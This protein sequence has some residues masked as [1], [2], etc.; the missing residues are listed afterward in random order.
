MKLFGITRKPSR[1]IIPRITLKVLFNL[2]AFQM[3]KKTRKT[4]ALL[5]SNL[6]PLQEESLE[7]PP[8]FEEKEPSIEE[9]LSSDPGGVEQLLEQ[10]LGCGQ[11][12][13]LEARVGA[14]V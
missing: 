14:C 3:G 10:L 6:K 1:S 7:T 9:D 4:S 11:A 8:S 12:C 13:E 5:R 2:Y